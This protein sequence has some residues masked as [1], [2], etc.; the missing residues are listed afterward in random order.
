MGED[1]HPAGARGLD[2]AERGDG[3][4]GAGGV[5]EPEAADGVRVLGRLGGGHLVEAGVV[6][7][8]GLLVGLVVVLL[9]GELELLLAG[10]RRGGERGRLG[11]GGRRAVH[12]RALGLGHERG[13]R[14]RE[15][16]DLVGGEDG[17][18][19]ERGLLLGEDAL[20]AEQEREVAPPGHRRRGGAALDLAQREVERAAAGGAGRERVGGVLAGM[21][22]ALRGESLGARDRGGI[23]NGRGAG[24]P[25]RISHEGQFFERW[26]A[27]GR[28]VAP[29]MLD[30]SGEGAVRRMPR[31]N[32]S[33]ALPSS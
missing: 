5:L 6:P 23:G 15:R 10:D 12:R 33:P 17:A 11:D 20:E 18:V 21:H 29:A 8:L 28:S 31:W 30:G 7:V 13:E 19:H 3:L 25:G 22:E 2:E 27:R 24:A 14:A 16:V 32:P 9:V 26:N 4:A 1:E